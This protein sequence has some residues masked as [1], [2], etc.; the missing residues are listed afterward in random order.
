M[1]GSVGGGPLVDVSPPSSPPASTPAAIGSSDSTLPVHA[2]FCD[3]CGLSI[4]GIRHKCL[5]CTDYD[6]CNGCHSYLRHM[7]DATHTFVKIP[8]PADV[9]VHRVYDNGIQEDVE[10]QP[11]DGSNDA[12]A[13]HDSIC[14]VC[15]KRIIGVRHK[16]LDCADYD[17]CDFCMSTRRYEAHDDSHNFAKIGSPGKVIVHRVQEPVP[18]PASVADSRSLA[19]APVAHSATCDMCDS[20]ILGDRY[21]CTRCPGEYPCILIDLPVITLVYTPDFDTCSSCFT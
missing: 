16:C 3:V 18:T 6:M 1:T 21:K 17:M 9:V 19:P 20:R 8:K 15:D 5:D 4:C 7:H 13:V 14:D 10:E 12:S 2:A 11:S